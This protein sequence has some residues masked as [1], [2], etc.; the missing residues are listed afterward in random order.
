MGEDLLMGAPDC[1]FCEY[2]RNL[3]VPGREA[4]DSMFYA[5]DTNNPKA[6][7]HKL[8]IPMR[9]I[10]RLDH[11]QGSW[12]GLLME[13]TMKLVKKHELSKKGYRIVINV[14][15]GGKQK[16][17]HVHVHVLAGEG[18]TEEGVARTL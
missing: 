6:E 13:A 14:G 7:F 4:I 2:T 5:I 12:Q 1:P 18:A 3:N 11:M 10:E 16:M 8:V 17:W 9:H 15:V